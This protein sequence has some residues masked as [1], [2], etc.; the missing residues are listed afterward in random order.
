MAALALEFVILT[1]ART[2]EVLG[3]TWAEMDLDKALWTVP[4]KRMKG[5]K[6]HRVP[7]S[8]RAIE[9]LESLRPLNA[10]RVFP[11]ESGGKLSDMAMT[12]LLRRMD[13][14]CTVHG[15][16]STFS[17]WVAECTA[18]AH[19]VREMS[20]AHAIAN[21]SEAAYRRGDMF[22][23]RRRLMAD[24]SAYCAST[25]SSAS[26]VTPIRGAA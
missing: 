1:A 8:P 3:A 22:E 11:A 12:M 23:K 4:A 14:D 10:S 25:G 26:K 16:R 9:I 18:Y 5:G 2:N 21:K 17:D 20:L 24:W 7:L 13:S 15:F 19:E 6:E